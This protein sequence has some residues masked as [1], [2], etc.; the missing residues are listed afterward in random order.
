MSGAGEHLHREQHR[1]RVVVPD[2]YEQ[3]IDKAHKSRPR[4]NPKT[5]ANEPNA[6]NPAAPPRSN[7]PLRQTTFFCA[8]CSEDCYCC[9]FDHQEVT[10]E[11]RTEDL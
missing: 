3:A 2:P 4:K 6:Q 1:R 9:P 5:P 10:N 7:K 8:G 11:V